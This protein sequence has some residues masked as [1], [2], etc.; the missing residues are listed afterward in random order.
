[1]PQGGVLLPVPV[2]R[3]QQALTDHK[4]QEFR[5]QVC[6]FRLTG[7]QSQWSGLCIH[8]PGQK[9]VVQQSVQ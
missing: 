5:K 2:P 8:G 7:L 9:S 3:A 6:I 1:M 4:H